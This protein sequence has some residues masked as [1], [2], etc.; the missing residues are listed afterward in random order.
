MRPHAARSTP[1]HE[2]SGV[3]VAPIFVLG[4]VAIHVVVGAGSEPAPTG[5]ATMTVAATTTVTVFSW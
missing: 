1:G 3:A 5:T 4:Q 2:N